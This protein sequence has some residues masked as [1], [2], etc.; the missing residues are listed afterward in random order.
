MILLR[1]IRTCGKLGIQHRQATPNSDEA[2]GRHE[3]FMG[4]FGDLVRI[5][6]YQSGLPLY[7]WPYAVQYA[8]NM[9]NMII[10]PDLKAETPYEVRYPTGSVPSLAHFGSLCTF[11]P[12]KIEKF[13]SR[14][15]RGIFV[16]CVQNPGGILS[17]NFIVIPLSCFTGG[18]KTVQ[19]VTSRDLCFHS[20]PYFSGSSLE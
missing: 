9:Y 10:L 12:T 6:L 5:V 20:K 3:R 14:S 17:D 1:N 13:I 11:V 15:R 8:A 18:L 7:L 16:G 2:N 4:V 19:F